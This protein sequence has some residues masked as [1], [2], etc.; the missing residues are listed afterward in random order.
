VLASYSVATGHSTLEDEVFLASHAVVTPSRRV[1]AGSRVSAGAVV[2]NDVPPGCLAAGNPARSLPVPEGT[3]TS[4]P[5]A[6]RA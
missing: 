6:P 3:G 1:G 5:V 2:F 4:S